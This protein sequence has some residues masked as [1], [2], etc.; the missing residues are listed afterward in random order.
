MK[1]KFLKAIT[2]AAVLLAALAY[3]IKFGGP[4]L[5]RQY[6]VMGVGNCQKIPV[7][8]LLPGEEV[9]KPQVTKDLAKD[10]ITYK[11]PTMSIAAPKGFSV[12]Q[13][14]IKKY[15]YK[16]K[17]KQS[18]DSIIYVLHEEKGFFIE[19]FPE[20]KKAGISNN[21]EF[22]KRA[23][24]ALPP[25]IKT[26]PDAFFVIMKSIF[27]PDV[28]DQ[29]KATMA[30]FRMGDKRGFITYNLSKTDNY[31]SCDIVTGSG[32]YFKV[33]IKD[34]GAKLELKQVFAII[35]TLAETD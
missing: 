25:D 19:L 18:T 3:L 26:F 31:F 29:K 10:Y 33:Y 20:A 34:K 5:L 27:I 15:Y 17:V 2:I 24:R 32:A 12:V 14:M 7:L 4:T 1:E 13:E 21:Y 11:F 23:M 35:S 16:K 28:G 9:M 30:Q 6:I 22:I 8:C